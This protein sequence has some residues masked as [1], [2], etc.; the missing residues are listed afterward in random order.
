MSDLFQLLSNVSASFSLP[1][2]VQQRME[3]LLQDNNQ[4]QGK[5]VEQFFV[6]VVVLFVWS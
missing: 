5:L 2:D 1:S 4:L 6:V 3:S